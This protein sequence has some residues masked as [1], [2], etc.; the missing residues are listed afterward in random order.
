MKQSIL[1]NYGARQEFK[2]GF[3]LVEILVVLGIVSL[4]ASLLFSGF[5]RYRQQA[6]ESNCLS[7]QRQVVAAMQMYVQDNARLPTGKQLQTAGQYGWAG[8]QS[9]AKNQTLFFC[10]APFDI[11]VPH[12]Y[13]KRLSPDDLS[14]VPESNTVVSYCKQHINTTKGFP[15]GLGA[16]DG[17][18]FAGTY[19][20][21]RWDGSVQRVRGEQTREWYW[22]AGQWKQYFGS[23]TQLT[24]DDVVTQRFPNEPWPLVFE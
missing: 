4:V 6:R 1:R 10:P 5:T 2:Q 19:T 12:R 13:E 8:Y 20:V 9:Y 7:N 22:R 23:S 16:D 14:L 21:A 18:Y 11:N 17:I 15:L 3:T 24:D